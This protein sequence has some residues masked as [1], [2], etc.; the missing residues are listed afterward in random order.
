MGLHCLSKRC[1]KQFSRRQKQSTFVMIGGLRVKQPLTSCVSN[2]C[3][4]FE[5]QR[6]DMF[7]CV[8]NNK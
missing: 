6:P 1:L 3:V 4:N 2:L 7:Y 5:E 8:L